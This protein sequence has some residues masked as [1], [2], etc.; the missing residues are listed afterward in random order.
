M[1]Y[2][3][4]PLPKGFKPQPFPPGYTQADDDRH[5]RILRNI[6]IGGLISKILLVG[7]FL[8]GTVFAFVA[9][10]PVTFEPKKEQHERR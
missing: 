10:E 3:N 6:R 2:N 4:I 7:G 9:T 8:G 5:Q 1:S